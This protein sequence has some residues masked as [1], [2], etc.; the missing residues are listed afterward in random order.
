M[1]KGVNGLVPVKFSS[2]ID[3]F[4]DLEQYNDVIPEY[5]GELYYERH[6]GTYTSQAAN[7]LWNR[8][9]ENMLHLVELLGAEG[10]L[11]GISYDRELVEKI[12][13]EVLLY[14]FH[15]ILPGSSIK[16]FYD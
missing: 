15:D 1:E 8:R 2:A 9:M 12:W 16:R 3:F 6:Q 10:K 4:E 11:R 14:Q 13:K 7:K 5:D